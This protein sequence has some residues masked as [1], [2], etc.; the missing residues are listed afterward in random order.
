[1]DHHHHSLYMMFLNHIEI[2]L[3][4][5]IS[6]TAVRVYFDPRL[7]CSHAIYIMCGHMQCVVATVDHELIV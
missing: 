2:C 1:M 7:C 3:L 6:S 5:S 4:S